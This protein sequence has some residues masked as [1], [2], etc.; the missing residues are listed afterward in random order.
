MILAL[1]LAACVPVAA[2]ATV[3]VTFKAGSTV[4]DVLRFSHEKLCDAPMVLETDRKR[5]LTL[6][7][8]GTAKGSQLRALVLMLTGAPVDS[9][10]ARPGCDPKLVAGIVPVDPWTRKV[11]AALR[12]TVFDCAQSE[13]RVVPNFKAGVANGFKLF[14]IRPG[15]VAEALGFQNGDVI[16]QVNDVRLV[17]P[18][19]AL[20]AYAGTRGAREVKF[21]VERKGEPRTITWLVF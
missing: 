16:V 10:R 19:L 9:P 11:P 4:E 6:A 2:D 13:G 12:D 1:L 3:K 8:D 21:A 17:S 5:P 14:G 7:V 18:E 15:G 20:E